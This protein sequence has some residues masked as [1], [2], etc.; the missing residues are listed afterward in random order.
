MRCLSV[1][2]NSFQDH[3]DVS[4]FWFRFIFVCLNYFQN[5]GRIMM[6][7]NHD[8]V[9]ARRN[10]FYFYQN[11]FHK[12]KVGW[13]G[14]CGHSSN[15]WSPPTFS[16][17]INLAHFFHPHWITLHW[18]NKSCT[19]IHLLAFVASEITHLAQF[20]LTSTR[21]ISTSQWQALKPTT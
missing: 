19:T 15:I 1:C 13:R 7:K 10:N 8:R 14:A 9:E 6:H 4:Q 12:K 18:M 11:Q 21:V 17:R 20:K 2:L 16:L 3:G 5:H